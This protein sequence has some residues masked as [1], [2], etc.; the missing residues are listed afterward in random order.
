M[1]GHDV[2]GYTSAATGLATLNINGGVLDKAASTNVNETL[3]GVTVNMT[4]GTWAGTGGRFDMFSAGYGDPNDSVNVLASSRTAF[5]T[6]QLN[7]RTVSPLFSVDSG[8]TPSGVDLLVS[9]Q[10]I[11][12]LGMTKDGPGVM[13]LT[14]TNT[15]TGATTISGGTLQLGTGQSGQDGAISNTS[16]GV[17]DNAALVYKLSGSENASYSITG[18]GSLTMTGSG[19]L[20]LA[21]S[22]NTYTGG[23]TVNNGTLIVTNSL[24]IDDGTN[25]SVGNPALLGLLP[26]PVIPSAIVPSAAVAP[27]PEPGTL[28]L[29]AGVLGGAVVYRRLRRRTHSSRSA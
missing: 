7:F 10:L 29:L 21:G 13:A 17:T 11:G 1:R 22:N 15:Y 26:A 16:S 8:T 14:N 6:A 28:A 3:T 24:A 27:V 20:I 2:F 23:T 18:S 12:S 9:G 19:T 4:G 25:L 5:I